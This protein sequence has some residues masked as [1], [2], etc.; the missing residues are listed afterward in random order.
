MRIMLKSK[1]HRATITDSNIDYEGS[2]TIDRKLMEEADILPFEQVQ[3]LDINN[4][5]R[6]T[7]YAIE[8]GP[9]EICVNGAAA[10]L[11]SLGDL[12][13]ILSYCHLNDEEA[14]TFRPKLVYV[15][16]NNVSSS[17]RRITETAPV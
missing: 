6:F 13:I 16:A 15:D 8:G 17:V 7:T 1:I 9:G 5:S 14:R 11:V 4:G 2:I 3:V 12:V 10:R